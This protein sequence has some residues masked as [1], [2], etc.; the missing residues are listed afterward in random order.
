MEIACIWKGPN[1][2][3]EGPMWHVAEKKLYWIDLVRHTLHC[4]DP[5]TQDYQEWQLPEPVG[6]VVPRKSGGLIATL[7]HCIVALELPDLKIKPIAELKPWPKDVYM[8]DGKCDRVGRFWFGVASR[9][10][11]NPMG[12]LYRLDPNGQIMQMESGITIS[13][14]LGFSPDDKKFYYT[15]G[16][17]YRIYEYDF[18]LRNGSMSRRKIFLQL[19]KSPVEPDG[20]T[21]DREGY[22]WEAQWNSGY[23][24]RYS[25]EGEL[26]QTIQ[27][28]VA[29]PTSCIFGG[30]D[31]GTLY[32]TSCSHSPSETPFPPPAGALFAIQTP[33]K[34]LPEPSFAG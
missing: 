28:P 30:P 7:G 3:G 13:N 8:N 29:R 12:G 2:L 33:V 23:I 17:K 20:L 26:D 11:E 16:L 19:E 10:V 14:G 15:D 4:L 21:V 34:G 22:V 9:D 1:A 31:M 32:I 24:F 5:V 27:M 6:C 25:P 18:D